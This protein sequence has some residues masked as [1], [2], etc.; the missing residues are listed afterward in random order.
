MGAIRARKATPMK[1]PITEAEVAIPMAS[2]A[3]PARASGNPS[4][5][6]AAFAGVPGI[7][8]RIA[9]REPP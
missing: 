5:V 8:R 1:V 4:R 2:P 7:F 6:V 3:R 9:E